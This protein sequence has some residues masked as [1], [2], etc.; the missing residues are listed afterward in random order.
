MGTLLGRH[1]IVTYTFHTHIL[2]QTAMFNNF[3]VVHDPEMPHISA[4]ACDLT[5][6]GIFGIIC[7]LKRDAVNAAYLEEL[8]ATHNKNRLIHK[9]LEE[10]QVSVL[11]T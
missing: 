3:L 1:R 2:Q 6:Y 8:V 9:Q 11:V 5:K 10:Y 4:F 7:F